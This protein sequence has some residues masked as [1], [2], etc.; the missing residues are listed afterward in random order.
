M[1]SEYEALPSQSL[2]EF[3][4]SLTLT[5]MVQTQVSWSIVNRALIVLGADSSSRWPM[6]WSCEGLFF[7]INR[8]SLSF[9]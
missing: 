1:F 2:A 7:L 3:L 5:T 4:P 9:C 6:R 8:G